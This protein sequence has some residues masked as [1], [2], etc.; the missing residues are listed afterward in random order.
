MIELIPQKC[1][2]IL[3]LTAEPIISWNTN[4][5]IKLFL[6]QL[7]GAVD[8][9]YYG[10]YLFRI[11]KTRWKKT[12]KIFHNKA[13]NKEIMPGAEGKVDI[14][15]DFTTDSHFGL[16]SKYSISWGAVCQSLL[17]ESAFFSLSH[18][19]ETETDLEAS[20]LLSADCFYKHALEMLRNYLES[21]ILQL[22]FCDNPSDFARWREGT[23]RVPSFRHKKK[24]LLAEI[25]DKGIFPADLSQTASE[26]YRDLNGSIH[27]AE[28]LLVNAGLL[29]GNWRGHTFKYD[30]FSTWCDYFARCVNVGILTLR[31]STNHWLEKRP[32]DS[33]YCGVCHNE[34]LVQFDVQKTSDGVSLI[35][36]LCGSQMNFTSKWAA[37]L[38]L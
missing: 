2:D 14:I 38:G 7:Y 18:I 32:R 13:I 22:Y 35:C 15:P 10:N 21:V 26:L 23:F 29:T 17:E 28:H 3:P 27:G 37:K 1:I 9:P 20:I 6:C 25:Q 8:Y 30:F 19:L 5:D 36:K 34:D 11:G 31:I 16:M 4:S 33:V 24:G 12:L